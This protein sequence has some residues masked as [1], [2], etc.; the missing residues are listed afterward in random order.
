MKEVLKSTGSSVL[1]FEKYNYPTLST[2]QE[3]I[4][5]EKGEEMKDHNEL[6]TSSTD[7]KQTKHNKGKKIEKDLKSKGSSDLFFEDP[8]TL[9]PKLTFEKP[10]SG[11]CN[12]TSGSYGDDFSFNDLFGEDQDGTT[13]KTKDV[14]K[15]SKKLEKH[16]VDILPEKPHIT[17]TSE[18]ISI[19][20][21]E[22]EFNESEKSN[23]SKKCNNFEE[24]AK[25]RFR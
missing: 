22:Q 23:E 24:F 21:K 15:L 3:Q 19:Q 9:K 16:T 18:P 7:Q 12:Q 8:N 13:Q 6:H 4:G 1:S 5:Y 2:N 20:K 10:L 14:K 25:K 11:F 17:S